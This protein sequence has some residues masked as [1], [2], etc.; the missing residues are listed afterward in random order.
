LAWNRLRVAK[1]LLLEHS[2]SRA[3]LAR[4]LDQAV[5][6]AYMSAAFARFEQGAY[7]LRAAGQT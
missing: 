5:A 1:E 6:V 3:L 7:A 4:A 2:A